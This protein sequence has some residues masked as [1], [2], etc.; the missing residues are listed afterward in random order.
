MKNTEGRKEMLFMS[1]RSCCE[2]VCVG[3]D[4]CPVVVEEEPRLRFDLLRF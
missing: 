2:C 1:L 4:K 3:G